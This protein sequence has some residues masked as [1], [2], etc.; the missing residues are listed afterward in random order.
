VALANHALCRQRKGT[1]E[2]GNTYSEKFSKTCS[3]VK[4]ASE[5]KCPLPSAVAYDHQDGYLT[6]QKEYFL[7]NLEGKKGPGKV[8]AIDWSKRSEYVV[9]YDAHD[10]SGNDAEQIWFSLVLN[11]KIAPVLTPGIDGHLVL[12]SC[13]RDNVGQLPPS[14][15]QYWKLKSATA[16]D[17]L[18]GD[19]TKQVKVSISMPGGTP[20][21]FLQETLAHDPSLS[22]LDTKVLGNFKLQLSVHD[23]AGMFG[24]FGKDNPT[25]ISTIIRVQDTT[26]PQIYCKKGGCKVH[27][28]IKMG[29]KLIGTT[30]G[31]TS[32]S[33]CCEACENQQWQRIIGSDT[34][35]N[36]PPCDF[37]HFS[38]R[39][40]ACV[41][42]AKPGGRVTKTD[43][44]HRRLLGTK[45][46]SLVDYTEE[47]A[48]LVHGSVSSYAKHLARTHPLARGS[49]V[50]DLS[51]ASAADLEKLGVKA[52]LA[53]TSLRAS[54]ASV[55]SSV[56]SVAADTRSG[57]PITGCT[58]VDGPI[59]HECGEDYADA[60]AR[61]ID[62]R[63]SLVGSA[64][65]DSALAARLTTDTSGMKPKMKGDYAVTYTCSD[66]TGHTE[67]KRRIV[68]VTDATP[69]T[70]TVIGE[71]TVQ[72][73]V[74]LNNHLLDV[75]LIP[76]TAAPP[77]LVH[78][79]YKCTE[80]CIDD[81]HHSA[82]IFVG[83]CP[84]TFEC[85]SA[86]G[87]PI[88]C[89]GGAGGSP[90]TLATAKSFPGTYGLKYTC[91]DAVGTVAKC[92]TIIT[93]H[94]AVGCKVTPWSFYGACSKTCG[95]SGVKSR[96]R[97]VLSESK[98]GGTSCPAL[99][100]SES[101]NTFSCPIDCAVSGW[102]KYGGCSKTCG[103]GTE[104]DIAH[105]TFDTKGNFKGNKNNV[106][107]KIFGESH[108]DFNYL[109]T[110]IVGE[111]RLKSFKGNMAWHVSNNNFK[112]EGQHN[113]SISTVD[114]M[115]IPTIGYQTCK[116][117]LS[118]TD[119]DYH[120]AEKEE[121]DKLCFTVFD[122]KKRKIVQRC[123]VDDIKRRRLIAAAKPTYMKTTSH[124]PGQNYK[125][126]AALTG[127][128][129]PD[130]FIENM[131]G[132]NRMT[133]LETD[134]MA[135]GA[136]GTGAYITINAVTDHNWE[137]WYADNL[138][139]T[140]RTAEKGTKM[141]SRSIVMD[142]NHGG[143]DCPALRISS[144]CN[145]FGC[146]VDCVVSDW[147]HFAG[148][149]KSCGTGSKIKSRSIL[150]DVAH[151][152]KGCPTLSGTA[153]CNTFDCRV[154]CVVSAWTKF[155]SCSERCGGGVQIRTRS[156]I[157]PPVDAEC[158]HPLSHNQNC[159]EH[160]CAVDCETGKWSVWTACTKSC[161]EGT[162]YRTVDVLTTTAHGGDD[163][164]KRQTKRCGVDPCPI[165][166]KVTK[167]SGWGAC[168]KTCGGGIATKHRTVVTTTEH[169]GIAC[170]AV[171][172]NR[173]CNS[174][175]C[176]VDCKVSPWS[177]YSACSSTCGLV[178]IHEIAHFTFDPTGNFA[179]HKSHVV[180]KIYAKEEAHAEY[181]RTYIVGECRIQSYNGSNAWHVSNNNFK[182]LDQHDCSISTVDMVPVKDPEYVAC[183]FS[184]TVTDLDYHGVE[185]EE[186]DKVCL[187]VFDDTK[188][189][190]VTE[191]CQVDD[192]ERRRLVDGV[193]PVYMKTSSHIPGQNWKLEAGL[194]GEKTPD[195]F[196]EDLAGKARKTVLETDY[197]SV[198]R[199]G[200]GAYF[201][202]NAVT[203]HNWEH[204]Y[205]DDL[206]MTCKKLSPGQKKKVRTILLDP[207]DGGVPCPSIESA[208][209]CNSFGCPIDC[210]TSGW[211]EFNSCSKT[212][213]SGTQ[214]KTRSIVTDVKYSGIVCPALTLDRVCNTNSCP[215][216]CEVSSW[217][218]FGGC[219]KSCGTGTKTKTRS[220]SVKTDHGG[221]ACPILAASA[222][223]NTFSC[224]FDCI[225][226][227]WSSYGLCSENCGGGIQSRTRSVIDESSGGGKE[228]PS[229]TFEQNCNAH[230]C[231]V[232]CDARD[233]LWT[234]WGACSQSCG[235]GTQ[236]R[237][238]SVATAAIHGGIVCPSKEERVCNTFEC[239]VD[240]KVT[241][242]SV[243]SACTTSCG[244]AV[245]VVIGTEYSSGGAEVPI[246]VH[247]PTYSSCRLSS[248]LLSFKDRVFQKVCYTLLGADSKKLAE[249]C[250]E[251]GRRLADVDFIGASKKAPSESAWETVS[252]SSKTT[253]LTRA[254][255]M[256]DLSSTVSLT[257]QIKKAVVKKRIEDTAA[258]AAAK[259]AAIKA[260]AESTTTADTTGPADKTTTAGTSKAGTPTAGT[261]KASTTTKIGEGSV[262]KEGGGTFIGS[263]TATVDKSYAAIDS[264]MTTTETLKYT[265][266]FG[267]D[268]LAES[269]YIPIAVLGTHVY[270]KVSYQAVN[271]T[272]ME[273]NIQKVTLTCKPP[274]PGQE[275]S[276]R[277]VLT[278]VANGGVSCPTLTQQ[279]DCNNFQCPIDC[280][281][282]GWTEFSP[283]S[284]KCGGGLKTKTR[285]IVTRP[286]YGGMACPTHAVVEACSQHPCAVDCVHS[287]N[288]WSAC[289]RSCATGTQSRT[290]KVITAAAHGG[291]ECPTEQDRLCSV[292]PCPIDCKVSGWSDYGTCSEECGGG[293]RS[294]TRTVETSAKYG[295]STCPAL[296]LKDP[297][298]NSHACPPRPILNIVGDSTL[299]LTVATAYSCSDCTCTQTESGV[300]A[301]YKDDGAVCEEPETGGEVRISTSGVD[302]VDMS[303]V[304]KYTVAYKCVGVV[305]G[306]EA[307]PQY[308]TV[309]VM[310]QSKP[311]CQYEG[312][313]AAGRGDLELEAGFAFTPPTGCFVSAKVGKLKTK[314]TITNRV[315]E[316]VVGK[317]ALT[318]QAVDTYTDVPPEHTNYAQYNQ[319]QRFKKH[320]RSDVCERQVT[321]VDTLKPVI[322]LAYDDDTH[323]HNIFHS[324]AVTDRN[325]VL[326]TAE[327][328]RGLKRFDAI[329]ALGV[330][331]FLY[332][333]KVRQPHNAIHTHRQP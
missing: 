332:M 148:C 253:T 54:T 86:D 137:H 153:T 257:D 173:D 133:V 327:K 69:P 37:F 178:P 161:G 255:T 45:T 156:V 41:M 175:K 329:H 269:Q 307:I 308:R 286:R 75:L 13:D 230:P 146:P 273:E 96:S 89:N 249:D 292:G 8:E 88:E 16:V 172:S 304:G 312:G 203:D 208:A 220:V 123:Q 111:C 288:L 39:R 10:G 121:N 296:V 132:K 261:A 46:V 254:A 103:T 322:Q 221:A 101:C 105:F 197:I 60:G 180:G 151:G 34:S 199:I 160:P 57:E 235:T 21:E 190:L 99:A 184:L 36:Q 116:F 104:R 147:G 23:H 212:C 263:K 136:I 316:H 56:G 236:S 187:S 143:G 32:L 91:T 40:Q 181:I 294:K 209:N 252:A 320:P 228:C 120:G 30:T 90:V 33:K 47:T 215:V 302:T 12:E 15:R 164:A 25:A 44:D 80:P 163:C 154:D 72:H 262:P 264:L 289:T 330:A 144:D 259:A 83:N 106:V 142:P 1:N 198:D 300:S 274:S 243:K 186:N 260:S 200:K 43:T 277:S 309:L 170:P 122:D 26:P 272:E 110:Y 38:V 222:S 6:V 35:K 182:D 305:T 284:E 95:P 214:N 210:K 7:V 177:K 291:D 223:C 297:D 238:F 285:S 150:T 265:M 246:S 176:P 14:K 166:C 2:K 28:K 65:S 9:K 115:R 73:F 232:D 29:G 62:M 139:M 234:D 325:P 211:S 134:Y 279:Y 313:T 241:P 159:N 61:C 55:K 290:I 185:K 81:L 229:L 227:V 71:Q 94:T 109:R 268:G 145:S 213:G 18:D 125:L 3:A 282:S 233:D 5:S 78:A 70:V 174:F 311:E 50:T 167:W 102:G 97:S 63:D 231:P 224:A 93:Q 226:S 250:Y 59:V 266:V 98:Y 247:S 87:V 216:D 155:S 67:T 245:P 74:D 85:M 202:I 113:C 303:V 258:A 193:K 192:I 239:P 19:L 112:D 237:T 317:Y 293:V 321:V 42:F 152:G 92:R 52:D 11:D 298:C 118:V 51:D 207:A 126:A 31:I 66:L 196:T 225:T 276:T 100:Q 140:C 326:I 195:R 280:K 107:A 179:G 108:T 301:V 157:T 129:T 168:T 244:I 319:Q 127:E 135:V 204:W 240:C 158:A 76:Q 299:I 53:T 114:M 49:V 271:K 4:Y 217:S 270:F 162:Q 295:G 48:L 333:P 205:T 315:D 248:P 119:L 318:Y 281:V 22:L 331:P 323:G 24:Q 141:K 130:R 124:I 20:R 219:S 171:V 169:G 310:D 183:K 149:S 278:P 131:A 58:S 242:W 256:L 206:K 82:K 64:I 27:S 283:C 77:Y 275:I 189:T 138:K 68:R 17:N 287:W 79:G 165:D 306:I 328:Y 251:K 84:G 188:T 117:S 201:T 194:T 267:A 128:A 324:G 218:S 314:V 191:R